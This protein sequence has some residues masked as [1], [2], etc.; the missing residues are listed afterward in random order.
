MLRPL[1][2][3]YGQIMRIRAAS[4][5]RGLFSCYSPTVPCVS[6]GNISWGGSG[7]TP[8]TGWLLAWAGR[9]GLTPAVLTRGYGGKPPHTP[10]LVAQDSPWQESGD[11]P[12]LLA[13][14]A[15]HARVV[16]DPVRK[17]SG[18]WVQQQFSPDLVVLD[19]GMQ[20]LAVQR[21]CNLVLLHPLDLEQ[22]WNRVVPC[23]PWRESSAALARA[24]A[25]LIKSF[26]QEF[27]DLVPMAKK[28]LARFGAPVFG[29]SLESEAIRH[30]AGP[31]CHEDLKTR[32][33]ILVTAVARPGQ[34]AASAHQAMGAPPME[35]VVHRDHHPFS[36]ADV[37]QLEVK[38]ERQGAEI[39][40]CTP[41]DAV[42][43]VG[44]AWRKPLYSLVPELRFHEGPEGSFPQWWE[45]TW[46]TLKET[47]HG[48]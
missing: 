17:R 30:V 25:F 3:A 14:A 10:Y 8:L 31:E 36:Q 44:L 7:K 40:V 47:V 19:D 41:K 12:L 23:G 22:H 28:R 4:Y 45:S 13:R 42:K 18:P 6:V 15:P 38:M 27:Q 29:F 35:R 43:L 2:W 24:H 5:A 46:Q 33:Y 39:A 21:H 9:Q 26:P 1:G 16:V 32:Q 34:V 20:H 11:E 48:P 37:A